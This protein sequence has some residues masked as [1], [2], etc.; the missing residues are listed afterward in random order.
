MFTWFFAPWIIQH[1][2]CQPLNIPGLKCEDP[3]PKLVAFAKDMADTIQMM[4]LPSRLIVCLSV[5]VLF[6]V[7]F[8]CYGQDSRSSDT[9]HFFHFGGPPSPTPELRVILERQVSWDAAGQ[10]FLNPSGLRLSFE[11]IDEQTTPG[12]RVA[13][14]YRVFAPGAPENKVFAFETWPVDKEV[15]TDPRDIYVNGQGLLM[16]HRPKPEQ[17]SSFKAAD[18]EVEI[19]P[20]TES[21]EPIRFLLT[22]KDGQLLVFGTLVPHP[23][24]ADDQGCSLEVRI[25]WSEP[26]TF[27]IIAD[28]FPENTKIPL[29]LESEGAIAKEKLVTDSDGHAVMAGNPSV[30]GKAQGTL[31]ATAEGPK[32]LPSVVLPW[33]AAPNAAPEI[34]PEKT[35]KR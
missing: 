25:A 14:R 18:D 26:A 32:C 13:A 30:P 6:L 16:I 2:A 19:T 8:F 5:Y 29:V 33:S 11:K 28:R 4:A 12:G 1:S 21:A 10:N 9:L 17:E 15:S 7:A 24:V 23:V 34:T 3:P 35:R 22:S 20:V 27:L 31:K